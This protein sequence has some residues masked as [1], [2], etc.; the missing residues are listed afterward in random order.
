MFY[1]LWMGVLLMAN[2]SVV[3]LYMLCFY[4]GSI[5][6][7][8]E[9]VRSKYLYRSLSGLLLM[10]FDVLRGVLCVVGVTNVLIACLV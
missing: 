8:M 3:F 4:L 7:V 1:I 10:F 9:A 2:C 5:C 6:V